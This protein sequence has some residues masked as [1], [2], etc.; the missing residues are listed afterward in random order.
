MKDKA[1]RIKQLLADEQETVRQAQARAKDLQ[2]QLNRLEHGLQEGDIVEWYEGAEPIRAQIF[3][4]SEYF[5]KAYQLKKDGTVGAFI[6][7]VYKG[8]KVTK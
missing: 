1:E 4:M 6:R 5:P 8:E 3:D 2:T 7:N